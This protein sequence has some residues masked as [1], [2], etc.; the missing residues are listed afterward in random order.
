[1]TRASL[2]LLLALAACGTRGDLEPPNGVAPPKPVW[3]EGAPRIW[4]R[5]RARSMTS[6]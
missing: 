5:R 6:I 3:A 4:H 1:M 2:L